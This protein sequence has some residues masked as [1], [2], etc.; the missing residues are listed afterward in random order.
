VK[1]PD[2]HGGRSIEEW[3]GK[4]PDSKVPDEVK[5]RVFLRHHGICHVSGIKIGPGAPWEAEHVKPLSMGGENR[6]S[7]LAPALIDPHKE[8]SAAEAD[9][10]SKA[11]RIK[12]KH[13]GLW[14]KA[15]QPIKSRG[16]PKRGESWHK[17]SDRRNDMGD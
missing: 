17:P 1:L 5:A 13:L 4:T 3:I 2:P 14:P 11:D 10:R 15:A 8:K 6:E 16:F 7:N 12:R 9:V